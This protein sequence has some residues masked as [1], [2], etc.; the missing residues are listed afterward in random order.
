MIAE[1]RIQSRR[2]PGTQSGQKMTPRYYPM[3]CTAKEPES[4]NPTQKGKK[5]GGET[6]PSRQF[7]QVLMISTPIHHV[8]QRPA[9]KPGPHPEKTPKPQSQGK[10]RKRIPSSPRDSP[11]DLQP[12]SPHRSTPHPHPATRKQT[13]YPPTT[14]GLIHTHNCR[15]NPHSFPSRHHHHHHHHYTQYHSQTRF[16]NPQPQPK[17]FDAPS[18]DSSSSA[19]SSAP[20]PPPHPFPTPSH[21]HHHH[22]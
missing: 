22:L 8:K 2:R 20:R 11:A 12:H 5:G 3:Y 10:S 1:P 15:S 13:Q 7:T 17:P 18:P 16:I 6:I 21:H 4:W 14:P 9:M 19:S